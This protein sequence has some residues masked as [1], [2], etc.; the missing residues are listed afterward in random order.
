[1]LLLLSPV[2][3]KCRRIPVTCQGRASCP[4]T[5]EDWMVGR[6]RYSVPGMVD[7]APA[8]GPGFLNRCLMWR[9]RPGITADGLFPC[10]P[11]LPIFR[12]SGS[13]RRTA[14]CLDLPQGPGDVLRLVHPGAAGAGVPNRQLFY[15]S[16]SRQ[17]P[18]F[19]LI[20]ASLLS[21]PTTLNHVR[22]EP[23][24]AK[25]STSGL[26]SHLRRCDHGAWNRV[27]LPLPYGGP[28]GC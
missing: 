12:S 28:A 6:L 7:F 19:V 9:A 16:N 3:P 4:Q 18:A 10:L 17:Y 22:Q 20:G 23:A 8:A 1:M 21:Q 25:L 26:R 13:C 15:S 11:S 5:A 24:V 2:N 27:I 14:G